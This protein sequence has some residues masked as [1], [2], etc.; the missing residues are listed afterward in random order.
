MGGQGWFVGGDA[1]SEMLSVGRR[2]D[3]VALR[4]RTRALGVLGEGEKKK[5]RCAFLV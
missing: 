4:G 1:A 3:V 2:G 5:E